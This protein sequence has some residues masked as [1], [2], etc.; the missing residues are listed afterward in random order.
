MTGG[1]REAPGNEHSVNALRLLFGAQLAWVCWGGLFS[2]KLAILYRLFLGASNSRLPPSVQVVFALA[3][4]GFFIV[5]SLGLVRFVAP[6]GDVWA[7]RWGYTAAILLGARAA[8]GLCQSALPLAGVDLRSLSSALFMVSSS[9]AAGGLGAMLLALWKG[10]LALDVHPSK[11]LIRF[12]GGAVVLQWAVP[13]GV[14]ALLFSPGSVDPWVRLVNELLPVLYFLAQ[15]LLAGVLGVTLELL[16]RKR[17]PSAA[18]SGWTR[19]EEGLGLYLKGLRGRVALLIFSAA[20]IALLSD[21]SD[22]RAFDEHVLGV[23]TLV[24]LVFSGMM[25]VGLSRYASLPELA[26]SRGYVYA[27]LVLLLSAEKMALRSSLAWTPFVVY[28]LLPLSL[29][30]LAGSFR[31][32]AQALQDEELDLSVRRMRFWFVVPGG[33]AGLFRFLG[34]R[35]LLALVGV[36]C[37]LAGVVHFFLVLGRVRRRMLEGVAASDSPP[38]TLFSAV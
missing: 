16:E 10:S 32:V 33:V 31:R 35:E 6:L 11:G 26:G 4:T 2:E 17:D 12:A 15:I 13:L 18:G 36:V 14:E 19:A 8:W 23:V 38:A 7:R 1:T 30:V 20:L 24:G 5:L 3:T 34:V 29:P 22:Y 9:L 21:W 37:V 28:V 27:S 25:L